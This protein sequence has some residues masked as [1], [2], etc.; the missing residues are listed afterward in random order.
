MNVQFYWDGNSGSCS[1]GTRKGFFTEKPLIVGLS[2][3]I[4]AYS[5]DDHISEKILGGTKHELNPEEITLIKRYAENN[6]INYPYYDSVVVDKHNKDPEARHDIRVT[7]SNLSEYAHR[8]AS[9]WT[10]E[11]NLKNV[12]GDTLIIP[13]D[14]IISDVGNFADSTDSTN[15]VSPANEAYDVTL[16]LGFSGLDKA[17]SFNVTLW[18]NGSEEV[19]SK[20]FTSVSGVAEVTMNQLILA[21]RDKLSCEITFTDKPTSGILVPSRTFLRVDNHGSVVAKRKG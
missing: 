21:E 13:W 15:W 4:I 10:T 19:M 8:V 1:F 20:S 12:V 2:Y 18:K 16:R 14:Y 9:L 3:D 6:S 7:L 5:E 17:I 11:I